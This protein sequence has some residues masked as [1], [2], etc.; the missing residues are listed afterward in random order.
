MPRLFTAL[1]IPADIG[2]LLSLKRGGISGA[3]WIDPE[4]YHVTL[5]FIGDLSAGT[6]RE[7]ESA[8]HRLR[9]VPPLD[10]TISELGIFGGNK[11]RALYAAISH[12]DQLKGLQAAHERLLQ[13]FGMPATGQKYTP[14]ITLA[15]L[16]N[17]SA[18]EMA[19]YLA[20]TPPF[21]PIRLHANRFVLYSSRDSIGGGP[22]VVEQAYDLR[23][24][25]GRMT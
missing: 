3:R 12:N 2:F 8:L 16:R 19:T 10:L 1:E 5:R 9:A 18:A 17:T 25:A 13:A 4:N 6:A 7:V 21:A 24:P 23:L 11:P 22:Y 20:T 15:R 14:H